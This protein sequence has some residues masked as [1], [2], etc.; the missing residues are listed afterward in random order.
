MKID[1]NK[2][3]NEECEKAKTHLKQKYSEDNEPIMKI[4]KE[5]E[6]MLLDLFNKDEIMN[7]FELTINPYLQSFAKISDAFLMQMEIVE[8]RDKNIDLFLENFAKS[9]EKHKD[10]VDFVQ[11][12]ISNFYELYD[13]LKLKDQKESVK[14]DEILIQ[15]LQTNINSRIKIDKKIDRLHIHTIN[16]MI[17]YENNTKYITCSVDKTIIIRNSE[18]N[19]II[20]ILTGHTNS[21]YDMLLLPNGRLASSSADKTIKIWNLTNGNCEQTLIGHTN[22]VIC[23]LELTNSI[24]LSG[25]SDKSIGLWDI[26]QTDKKELQFYHQVKNEKQSIA[27]SMALINENE[28][29]VT[30]DKDINIYLFDNVTNKSFDIIKTLKGHIALVRDIKFMKNSNDLLVVALRIKLLCFGVYH[31]EIA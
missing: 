20:R 18:D 2:I 12:N 6:Q 11:K 23:L 10:I 22:I 31:R 16:K 24:L 25:S 3:I 5:H 26:S 28:L 30:S 8:N 1:I 15:K 27:F 19:T 7:N 17:S 21:V 4:V 9:N 13:S 14:F 29:A